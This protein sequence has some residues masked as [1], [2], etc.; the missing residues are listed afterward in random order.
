MEWFSNREVFSTVH[1]LFEA[2][3]SGGH[4]SSD[5]KLGY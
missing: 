3:K 5:W 1:K 4:E 2:T